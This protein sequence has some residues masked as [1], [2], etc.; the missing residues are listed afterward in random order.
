MAD[1]DQRF[2][3]LLREFFAEFF[4]LF[5]PDWAAR[6]DFT[7]LTW[8]DKE[9]FTDPPQGE[10]RYVDLLARLPTRQAIPTPRGATAESWI[11]LV[12]IEIEA[13]DTVAP[14]RPRMFAYYAQLRRDYNLP[15][16]PI[17][18]YLRV[19]LEGVGWDTY[20]EHFWD[21]QLLRFDYAY[22]GLPALDSTAYVTG[23]NILGVALAALMRV[24]PERRVWLKEQAFQRIAAYAGSDLQR[25]L[26][27]ECVDAYLPMEAP[28]IDEFEAWLRQ[29]S[30][31]EVRAM[32]TTL[33]GK[34]Y[35]E[36]RQEGFLRGQQ[37]AAQIMLTARFGILSAQV[38]QRLEALSAEQLQQLFLAVSQV[39]SLQELGLEE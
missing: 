7:G 1:H 4:H 20:S 9:V 14:L 3:V 25:F 12:H 36:G 24:P 2:K 15:V 10:R 18:L 17:G 37:Q 32:A 30:S 16:L 11:A 5:F 28:Q 21:Q 39:T 38:Q 26:L 8:L 35:E 19:G 22:I 34:Y 29:D 6:F 27:F 31:Q 23:E 33:L 13:D